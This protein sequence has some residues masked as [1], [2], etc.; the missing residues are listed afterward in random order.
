MSMISKNSHILDQ[1]SLEGK[2]AIVTGGSSGIGL[3]SAELL[4]EVGA[5]CCNIRYQ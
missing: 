5:N 3:A 4:A 2:I 1:I